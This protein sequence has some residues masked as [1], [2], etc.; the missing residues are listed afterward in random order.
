[1]F[2]VTILKKK[3]HFVIAFGARAP[4]SCNT[5]ARDVTGLVVFAEVNRYSTF[6]R[7]KKNCMVYAQLNI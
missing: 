1:M 6:I 4:P 5:T 7:V 3:G 2:N